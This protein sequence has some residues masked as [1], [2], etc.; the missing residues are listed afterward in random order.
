MPCATPSTS[1]TKRQAPSRPSAS[2]HTLAP[3]CH[4]GLRTQ[5]ATTSAPRQITRPADPEV[6]NG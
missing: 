6:P 1:D 5:S 3:A 2:A 4:S